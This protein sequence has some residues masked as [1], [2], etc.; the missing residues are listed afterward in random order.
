MRGTSPAPLSAGLKGVGHRCPQE[1]MS[2]GMDEQDG[3]V[4]LWRSND[5]TQFTGGQ[6]LYWLLPLSLVSKLQ[7]HPI[8]KVLSVSLLQIQRQSSQTP[9][10]ESGELGLNTSPSGPVL[11]RKQHLGQSSEGQVLRLLLW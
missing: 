9:S 4:H 11:H 6:V 5:G 3:G 10:P 8:R 7:A 2:R 1:Q